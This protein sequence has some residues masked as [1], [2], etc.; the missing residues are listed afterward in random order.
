M[1]CV[2]ALAALA[3][4]ATRFDTIVFDK[5]GLTAAELDR[6]KARCTTQASRPRFFGGTGLDHDAY[7]ACMRGLGYTAERVVGPR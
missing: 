4:C 3:G 2:V 7:L 1:T 5:P 6:D